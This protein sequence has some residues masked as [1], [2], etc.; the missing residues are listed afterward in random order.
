MIRPTEASTTC[1]NEID[2]DAKEWR[3]P[4][5]R[6]K[7]KREHIVP[8]SAQALAI[9]EMMKPISQHRDYVFPGYRNPLEPMNSQTANVSL[10]VLVP[11]TF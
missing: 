1:W 3:I 8:L 5:G 11:R 7:M 4:A 2:F 9:L 6:M 10:P